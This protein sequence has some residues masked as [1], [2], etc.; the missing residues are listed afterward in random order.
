MKGQALISGASIAGLTLAYWLNKSGCKVTIV[1]ISPGLRRGGSPI[2]VRGEAL[3]VVKEMGILEKIKAKEFIHTDEIV[4]AENET[5]VSFSLNALPEYNGDIEIHRDDLVDI[6]YENIPANEVEFLFENRIE[7]ITQHTGTVAVTFRNGE[8][9]N[10]DF[11]YGA[12]GTHSAVRKL[13]F[14]NEE[15][16][17]R[18]FG[19]YFAIAEAPDMKPDKPNSA[20]IYKEA[21]KAA[22]IYPFKEAVYAF[23][24]FRSPKLNY[25]YKDHEQHKQIL[26]D[27]F[28]NGSWRIPEILD[29]M[30]H[31]GNLYFDEVCQIHMASWAKGRVALVGDAAH[32][33][34][35]PTGM[36][37][38]LAIQ[39]ATILAKALQSHDDYK[40]AFAKY[41]QTYRPYV[42]SVQARIVRGLNFLLPETEEGIQDAIKRFKK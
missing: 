23:L 18:F 42:E 20:T 31:S 16:Y 11:V 30:L 9:R 4:N 39:G 17:S 41:M 33:T 1:E 34:S 8:H 3:A 26:E 36:G 6:L 40:I 28:K 5:L 38:S 14:G 24:A 35:F 32:T 12:D 37:T 2:D 29:A 15:N 21:G 19:A 27:H 10:F 22:A 13:V 25:D 7:E